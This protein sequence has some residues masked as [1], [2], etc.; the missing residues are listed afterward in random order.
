MASTTPSPEPVYT[1]GHSA[2]V[3]ASHQSRTVANSASFLLPHLKNDNSNSPFTLVDLGCGPGTIT[4]GFCNHV[5]PRGRVIGIDASA[6]VIAQAGSAHPEST[7]PNLE[8]RVG[9]ITTAQLPFADGSVDVVFTHQTLLHIPIPAAE[10]VVKEAHRILKPD[11]RGVLAMREAVALLFEPANPGTDAYVRCVD[12]AV[13]G[14]GA[15]GFQAGRSLH[16]WAGRAGFDRRKMLVGAGANCYA[17]PEGEA[18]WWA[19]VHVARLEGE[20]GAGWL[21]RQVVRGKAEIDDMKAG[22]KAWGGCDEAWA[23]I[24]QEEVLCWK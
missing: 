9:D 3:L 20:V 10:R 11:G 2:S 15:A 16:V 18:R 5:P 22:L 1:Q 13:R 8:F 21:D 12:A 23:S 19:D 17:G 14:T 6:A 24:V 4:S 7:Y